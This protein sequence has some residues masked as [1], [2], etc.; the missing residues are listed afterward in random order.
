MSS[1]SQK[2]ALIEPGNEALSIVRQCELLGL[3]RASFYYQPASESALNL[4]LMRIIDEQ[5]TKTPFYGVPRM[6]W[7]LRMKGYIVGP[8][9]IRRLMRLMGIEA[10]CPKRNLSR[11]VSGSRKF[12][13]LLKELSIERPDQV[14]AAD[15]S[16]LQ[17][18]RD[19]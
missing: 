1:N 12:P 17:Q 10:I 13:Y 15:I 14:W 5:F 9:R 3:P 2:H 6:T 7:T 11:L 4:E 18:L 16:V 8:K 19:G